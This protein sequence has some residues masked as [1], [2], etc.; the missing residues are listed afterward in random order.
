LTLAWPVVLARSTQAIIGFAD[1]LMIAPLG[2]ESLAAVT[3]GAMNAFT[4]AILPMG[5][6]FI[7]QSFAAQLSGR[8]DLPGARRYGW[9]GLILSGGIALLGL[10]TLP[11]VGPLLGLLDFVPEVRS[12]MTDYLGIRL[13]ALGAVVGTE[14]LGNWFGGLGNTRLQM[15]GSVVAMVANIAL[16][17]VFIHGNLGAPALGVT[18]AAIASCVATWA[19]FAVV[20]VA[21]LYGWGATARGRP[22]GLKRSEFVR[23]LRFGLPNGL[24][25]FLEFAA[26]AVF[27]NVVLAHLG[28]TVLAAMMVVIS[29]NSMAFMPAFGV[30]SAG[31]ILAGQA[32]GGGHHDRVPAVV[33]ITLLATCSWMVGIGLIYLSFPEYLFAWFTPPGQDAAALLEVGTLL[34]TL[35]AIWQLSDAVAMTMSE[36]LRSAGDTVWP[37]YA[38]IVLA[39]AVFAPASIV[40]V[41]VL[42]GGPVAALLC[43]AG[44]LALLALALFARFRSGRWREIDLIGASEIPDLVP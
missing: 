5:I 19:G 40:S 37:L 6:M 22:A 32:I 36:V 10:G 44:F 15:I 41:M 11:L 28:T 42:D 25:W 16:N 9:Y 12:L 20:L 30:C 4:I 14:A 38:R 29:I 35:S 43:L 23:V 33:R 13:L 1:A 27:V 3:T 39:W 26:F 8:G 2:K 7:V 21:F 17:W 24:N 34:L 31:A 18:G